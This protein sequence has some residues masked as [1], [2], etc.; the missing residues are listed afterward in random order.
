MSRQY[1]PD[2]YYALRLDDEIKRELDDIYAEIQ[3]QFSYIATREAR[4]SWQRKVLGEPA[5]PAKVEGVADAGRLGELA[6]EALA[7]RQYPSAINNLRLAERMDPGGAW[8]QRAKLVELL[9]KVDR[10]VEQYISGDEAPHEIDIAQMSETI[11][12]IRDILPPVP[13][14]L[15]DLSVFLYLHG[16]DFALTRDMVQ[17]LLR[18]HRSV[19]NLLLAARVNL[20]GGLSGTALDLLEEVQ[21][22]VPDHPDLKQLLKEAKRRT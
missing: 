17:R 22:T 18:E 15:R 9:E 13:R 3:N 8:G 1:H 19:D 12:K 6:D 11:A 16:V 2:R 10:R 4:R 21:T 5:A 20:K 14:L 7:R